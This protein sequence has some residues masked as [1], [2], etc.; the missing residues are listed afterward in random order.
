[1]FSINQ[2]RPLDCPELQVEHIVQN[3]YDQWYME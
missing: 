3:Q 2:I 1:M